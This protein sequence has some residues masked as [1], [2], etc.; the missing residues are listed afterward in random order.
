V[1]TACGDRRQRGVLHAVNCGVQWRNRWAH[2]REEDD[3]VDVFLLGEDHSHALDAGTD[4]S[5]GWHAV[6]K[7]L[8]EIEIERVKFARVTLFRAI[9]LAPRFE[10]MRGIVLFGPIVAALHAGDEDFESLD[11]PWVLSHWFGQRRNLDWMAEHQCGLNQLRFD[12]F[13]SLDHCFAHAGLFFLD[14]KRSQ[15]GVGLLNGRNG[16]EVHASFFLHCIRH[17]DA[18]PWF[19]EIDLVAANVEFSATEGIDCDVAEHVFDQVH[20]VFVVFVGRHRAVVIE[21]DAGGAC[22]LDKVEVGY[23]VP[24]VQGGHASPG[25]APL[26]RLRLQQHR[27]AAQRSYSRQRRSTGHNVSIRL[28]G[29]SVHRSGGEWSL[30]EG[31][32]GCAAAFQPHYATNQGT[33]R[34]PVSAS[35]YDPVPMQRDGIYNVR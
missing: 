9:S 24:R 14:A 19:A 15:A 35:G 33:A 10:Q 7:C 1:T 18:A 17:A 32:I 28:H 11:K 16:S 34:Q 6:F 25:G 22:G 5:R 13:E 21:R 2:H 23:L 3:V 27:R 29:Y 4:T 12:E 26:H 20:V 31:R 30:G 8:D